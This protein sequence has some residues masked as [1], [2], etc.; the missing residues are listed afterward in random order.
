[1]MPHWFRKTYITFFVFFIT[2]SLHSPIYHQHI[3]DHHPAQSTHTHN[4][5]SHHPNDY[6]LTSGKKELI[7]ELLYVDSH[8]THYHAHFEKDLY[9]TNRIFS[10]IVKIESDI[11]LLTYNNLSI[12]SPVSNKYS[13]HLYTSISYSKTFAKTS[14][15]L[16]PPVYSS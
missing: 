7:H 8:Q 3:D 6:T 14:S 13:Y 15:G 9:R 2:I 5:D 11:K 1:M 4:I 16:S 12:Q 10:K